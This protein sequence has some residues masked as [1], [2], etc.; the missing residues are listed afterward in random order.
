VAL[1]LMD[2]GSIDARRFDSDQNLALGR[3]WTWAQLNL[4]RLRTARTRRDNDAHP[5]ALVSH[6]T[7]PHCDRIASAASGISSI[8]DRGGGRPILRRS[9]AK[10]RKRFGAA[11]ESA[12][13]GIAARLHDVRQKGVGKPEGAGR[14]D[15]G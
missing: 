4:Q 1:A 6:V 9:G 5:F 2:V 8:G 7:L 13:I 12:E 14:G 3:N 10:R 15:I 11:A